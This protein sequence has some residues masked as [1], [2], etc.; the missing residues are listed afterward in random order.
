MQID[1][2]LKLMAQKSASDFFFTTGAPASVKIDGVVRPISRTP[3]GVGAVKEMAYD[4][5][6][7]EQISEF[8]RHKEMN[9]GLSV[10]GLGRFRVN[11]YLQ[12]GEVAMVIRYIKSEI[13][14]IEQL[15]LPPVLKDLVLHN[16]GLVLV[17]GSTGSGKSTTLASMIDYR[18][19]TRT[20]H[21][22]R[23]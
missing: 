12:R 10:S 17:V 20:G 11:I 6:S 21:I 7:A 23:T 13:P 1:P 16:N 3:L 4:L 15:R 22:Q 18:N 14:T 5:M 19:G 2:Y 9:L 8:E